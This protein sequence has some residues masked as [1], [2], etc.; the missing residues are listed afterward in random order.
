MEKKP[1][2]ENAKGF[3]SSWKTEFETDNK[4]ILERKKKRDEESAKMDAEFK[5]LWE[6]YKTELKGKSKIMLE[7]V[8]VYYNSFSEALMKGTA[9]I[10]E[11]LQLEKRLDELS[12]FFQKTGEIGAAKINNF[13]NGA[14]LKLNSFDTELVS[15]IENT[16]DVEFDE[17]KNQA[18][19]EIEKQK[20]KS[21][22]DFDDI[23]NIF[24]S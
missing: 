14:K 19:A 24:K 1:F 18:E 5:K 15:D 6:E 2:S 13:V 23:A 10:S 21:F 11:K 3:L 22:M 12:T 16:K 8:I 20:S 17:V 4:D 7:N 9:T